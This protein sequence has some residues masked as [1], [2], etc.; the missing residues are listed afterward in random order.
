M[1]DPIFPI[2]ILFWLT[3]VHVAL[4]LKWAVKAG[5]L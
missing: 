4:Y 1:Q 2:A 5:V 3:C